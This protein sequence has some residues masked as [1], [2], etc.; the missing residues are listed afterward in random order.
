MLPRITELIG[1]VSEMRERGQK[2]LADSLILVAQETLRRMDERFDIHEFL[3]REDENEQQTPEEMQAMKQQMEAQA[4]QVE[5]L[6]A[7]LEETKS[8][9]VKN[10]AQAEKFAEEADRDN[11][12][13]G[14]DAFKART[15]LNMKEK[16]MMHFLIQAHAF[17]I[18]GSA[19]AFK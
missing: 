16:E 18:F 10:L 3:P 9:T 13:D 12:R 7:D 5:Q 17:D 1:S 8:K 19:E 15:D 2:D 6:K 11:F 14:L 4:I